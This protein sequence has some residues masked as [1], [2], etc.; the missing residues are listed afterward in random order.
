MYHKQVESEIKAFTIVVYERTSESNS[1]SFAIILNAS[2]LHATASIQ[3]SL[4][5]NLNKYSSS[6]VAMNLARSR[7]VDT[8]YTSFRQSVQAVHGV[9]SVQPFQQPQH[10]QAQPFTQIVSGVP[11]IKA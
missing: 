4:E 6:C 5:S 2:V 11:C 3:L 9:Q 7:S 1:V 10:H 8:I